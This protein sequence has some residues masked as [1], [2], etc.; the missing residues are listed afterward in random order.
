MADVYRD[1]VY[2]RNTVAVTDTDT[3]ITVEDVSLFPPAALVAKQ[4]FY[5]AF[6][7]GLTYPHTFEIM[8]LKSVDTALKQLTV[9]RGQGGTV[10][11]PHSIATYIKG[12]LTSDMLR[13]LRSGLYGTQL[14]SNDADGLVIGDR[15]YHQDERRFYVWTGVTGQ[16]RDSFTRPNSATT[17]GSTEVGS[18]AAGSATATA[19]PWTNAIGVFGIIDNKAYITS[20]QG[21]EAIALTNPGGHD[22]D[23]SMNVTLAEAA[24]AVGSANATSQDIAFRMNVAAS[25]GYVV[26]FQR[27]NI[28]LWRKVNGT[29]A[30]LASV[31]GLTY[32]DSATANLRVIAN[33]NNIR[34]LLDGS[35]R[36]NF[37]ETSVGFTVGTN[38]SNIGSNLG[39]RAGG[40][41]SASSVTAR[42]DDLVVNHPTGAI[43]GWQPVSETLGNAERTN[44]AVGTTLTTIARQLDELLPVVQ[45]DERN[46]VIERQQTG[47]LV[48]QTDD[49]QGALVEVEKR[50]TVQASTDALLAVT[51]AEVVE[52]LRGGLATG[53]GPPPSTTPGDGWL[54]LDR[55]G[56]RIWIGDGGVWVPLTFS[57]PDA[58][59]PPAATSSAS[60]RGNYGSFTIPDTARVGDVAI[61]WFNTVH[62]SGAVAAPSG[63]TILRQS[64]HA[65]YNWQSVC[66]A[67]KVLTAADMTATHVFGFTSSP[68]VVHLRTYSGQLESNQY[69]A[70]ASG[71][72]GT[73]YT[74]PAITTT[75][76]NSVV[77]TWFSSGVL[78]GSAAINSPVQSDAVSTSNADSYH[79][80]LSQDEDVVAPG[81]VSGRTFRQT[82]AYSTNSWAVGSF[83]IAP[84]DSTYP[85][86]LFTGTGV[87]TKT[88]GVAENALY[89]D[90]DTKIVYLFR[91]GAWHGFQTNVRSL[92]ASAI[93]AEDRDYILCSPSL[94]LAEYETFGYK[95]DNTG[96][97]LVSARKALILAFRGIWNNYAIT[98]S[99]NGVA[100][101]TRAERYNNSKSA[102]LS[103]GVLSD[104]ATH[105]LA[106]STAG[107]FGITCNAAVSV[108]TG[109]PE[110]VTY[111]QVAANSMTIT[112]PTAGALLVVYAHVNGGTIPTVASTTAGVTWTRVAGAAFGSQNSSGLFIGNVPSGLTSV[113]VTFSPNDTSYGTTVAAMI[114]SGGGS[115]AT[116]TLPVGRNHAQ[117]FVQNDDPNGAEVIVVPASGTINGAAQHVLGNRYQGETYT[118]DGV[119]W[120]RLPRSAAFV[121][122]KNA[123][124]VSRHGEVVLVDAAAGP[125]TITLPPAAAN[126]RV[127]VKK[128]DTSVNAVTI[129]VPGATPPALDGGTT[130]S[131]TTPYEAR[132]FISDGVDWWSL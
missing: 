3:T 13:R 8:K 120:F 72:T 116:V 55:S 93:A 1:F 30:N 113:A 4:D 86:A 31:T 99:L 63:W 119:N 101:T 19:T 47:V 124:Y 64:Q 79:S 27:T 58:Y 40:A 12:T 20:V 38:F 112:V 125:V 68:S 22:I 44:Y 87:P 23:F 128:I 88:T 126:E 29:Y 102:V 123:N 84:V 52:I 71:G 108:V 132:D 100:M 110:N 60:Y 104:P 32:A 57:G 103:T 98:A 111:H 50:T 39:V 28:G 49:L 81:T 92:T 76:P 74:A 66:V 62:T 85:Q 15:F 83:V 109:A 26:T 9:Q 33:G 105:S 54:Y 36:I 48:S 37:N 77:V 6:E 61:A 94:G 42:W 16:L 2:T 45:D 46:T 78:Y 130:A 96:I 117:V 67:Q 107:D 34:V 7:S 122:R 80:Q 89:V 43:G 69:L 11:V 91:D 17:M 97:S 115:T 95:T 51:L 129:T 90:R 21:S 59:K 10:A 5:V 131:I 24:Y 56:K 127:S 75:V 25:H 14:P 18:A 53:T 121:V 35:D 106:Y 70:G 82:N 73:D 118:S 41:S 114:P 65:G